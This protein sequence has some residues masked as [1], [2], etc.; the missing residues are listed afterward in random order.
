MQ[1]EEDCFYIVGGGFGMPACGRTVFE[2][3]VEEECQD[4]EESLC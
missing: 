4:R 2:E 3:T 1:G